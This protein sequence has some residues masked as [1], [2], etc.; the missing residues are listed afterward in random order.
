[1]GRILLVCRLAARDLRRRPGEA[2][3]LLLVITAAATTLTLGLA[4]HGVTASASY[5]STRAATAG[6][7]VVA[8][9]G[10]AAR[11]MALARAPGVI[12]HTGP[13]PVA[14]PV[15]RTRGL[16]VPVLAEGRD[17]APAPL[18]QP[19][20]TQGTW[21][22]SSGVVIER[23][24]ADTLGIR[25]GD[26]VTLNGR[27]FRVAGIA[28]TAANPTDP[29][30]SPGLIW[31]TRA[32]AQ[33]LA[34]SAQPLSFT[35]NLKLA[36]PAGAPAFVSAHAADDG[37]GILWSWEFIRGLD[38]Q[39]V[40]NEQLVML[41]GSWLLGLLAVASVAV[42]V[43]GRMAEQ[44][45]RVGLLK[46]VG[47][48]PGLVAAVLLA[49]YL[50]LALIAAAAGLAAGWLAAPLLTRPSLFPGLASAPGAA[51]LTVSTVVLVAAA[52]L[53]VAMAAT[54]VPGLRAARTSTVR[55]LADAARPPRRR[56]RVIAISARLPVPLLL[57]LRLAARRPRRIL[58]SGASI[59]IT[60][61]T[62][63][64]VLVYRASN[65][66][67]G[68]GADPVG[69]V[70]LIVTVA[71]VV[72]AAVNA[73]FISWATVLDARRPS[74][75]ARAL[76][77]KPG[78]VTAGLSAAQLLP[79]LPAAIVGIPAGIALYAAVSNGQTLT[80][81]PA[82]QL[83]AV[84]AATLLVVAGLTAIPARI[85]ARHPVAEILQSET[86]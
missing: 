77:A 71:L 53:G 81:P 64:A 46:A 42:L 3:L 69:Q 84:V 72:L 36:D 55:A 54:L 10:P 75:L 61:S 83:L 18:D 13:Y 66:L 31:L 40:T 41:V 11:V 35:L 65:A 73:I 56:A 24:F 25:A 29:P 28:V 37:T 63:V 79:A 15:L 48:T 2:V 32:D 62:I 74:A 52:A 59:A 27:P 47:G 51:P 33:S 14:S 12:G 21:V 17:L 26:S 78:Q 39:V 49:E 22:R 67:G 1:M 30:T 6:P 82:W 60:V 50:V 4:L 19:K 80:I 20:L 44:T 43:G 57:G 8:W 85:G 76:G 58:L 23:S 34:T 38:T 5:Q 68:P 70:M 86:A 7:D 16:T 45:R 9:G